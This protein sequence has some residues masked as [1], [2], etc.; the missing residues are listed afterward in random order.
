MPKTLSTERRRPRVQTI[1]DEESKTV[2]SDLARSEIRHIL[3]KY[4]QTGV[5][6]HLREVDLV[7]RDV[8][9]FEDFRDVMV[10]SK[11]AEAE[12]LK[13]PSKLREVFDHD[14]SRWLDVAHDPEKLEEIRPQLE[15][16][17]VL[18]P[19]EAAPAPPEPSTPPTPTPDS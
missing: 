1:N 5:I 10:Q 13:L 7:F 14:V 12:F 9:E 8:T 16:L 4:R 15:K 11:V 18:K 2:Q 6:T 3:A 19:R 17:G